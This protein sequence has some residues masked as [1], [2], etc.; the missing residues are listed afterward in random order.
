VDQRVEDG[1]ALRTSPQGKA[2]LELD[3]GGWLL[4][5]QASELTVSASAVTLRAGRVWVDAFGPTGVT[6][7]T[8]HG[9]VV[10]AKAGFEVVVSAADTRVYCGS[11]EVTIKAGA[12]TL[13]IVSGAGGIIAAG[14]I[15]PE[16]K[17]VWTDWTGGLAQAG[18]REAVRTAGLGLL[19][20]RLQSEVGQARS[21]LLVREHKVNARVVGPLAVTTV[22]QHFFNPRSDTVI[23][24]YRVRLPAGAIIRSFAT[25]LAG[26]DLEEAKIAP[27]SRPGGP[28]NPG[29]TVLEWEA[30][31]RYVATL[32]SIARGA[33][34]VVQLEYAEWLPPQGG[35]RRYVYPMGG[36]AAPK[37]GELGIEIDV[38]KAGAKAIKA[39]LDARREGDT[40]VVR[41]SD[42]VPEADLVVEL[43]DAEETPRPALYHARST[44]KDEPAYALLRVVP[45]FPKATPTSTPP[46][47]LVVVA[48]LSAATGEAE[49]AM[50][51][52]TAD[53]L[54]R[55]LTPEDQVGLLVASLDATPLGAGPALGPASPA[56]RDEL[57]AAL[58]KARAGGGTD[59]EAAL[60]AAAQLLPRGE[61]AVVYLGD[62][63]PTLGTLAPGL[64][65]ERLRSRLTPPRIFAVGIGADADLELLTALTEGGGFTLP[66]TDPAAAPRAAL[67][68]AAH[69]AR[70]TLRDVTVEL[71]PDVDRI[72]PAHPITLEAGQTFFAL[73]RLRGTP[74]THA[75]LRGLRDGQPFTT[76]VKLAVAPVEDAGDLQRRWAFGRIQDLLRRG[77]GREAITEI[78]VRYEVVSPFTGLVVGGGSTPFLGQVPDDPAGTYVPEALRG[79][80][81]R[82]GVTLALEPG[83]STSY[84][85]PWSIEELYQQTLA[86]SVGPAVAA[87][88]ERKAASQP[89]LAGS[90]VVTV[91]V[92]PDGAVFK[93]ALL[94]EASTLGDPDIRDDVL[95]LVQAAR[96]PA[97][98]SGER[99][100][101]THTFRFAPVVGYEVPARCQNKDGTRKR[102]PESYQYLDVRRSLWRERLRQSPNPAGAATLW[103]EALVCGEVQLDPD[104]RALLL[105]LLDG[106]GSTRD[107]V[108]LHQ[109]LRHEVPW[110]PAF[111]RREILR[112]LR[113]LDDVTVVRAGLSLDGGVDQAL[114]LRLLAKAKNDAEKVEIV[115]RFHQLAPTSLSLRVMLL[116]LFERT[117]KIADAEELAWGLR[118]DPGVDAGIRQQLAEFFLRRGRMEEARRAFSETVEFA[119]YDPWARRRL[120]HLYLSQAAQAKT[121]SSAKG[122]AW[123]ERLYADAYR[124]FETLAWLV[125]GDPSVLLLMANAAAGMRRIDWALR[126]QERV[127]E[128]AEVGR[129]ENGPAEW[130]R[131][132]TAARLAEL[133]QALAKDAAR[134][135]E[136]KARGR[137]AGLY[138]WARDLSLILTWEH[139]DAQLALR[140]RHPGQ[141]AIVAAPIRGGD[142]AV[143]GVR[144]RLGSLFGPGAAARALRLMKPGEDDKDK[145]KDKDD[146]KR[147]AALKDLENAPLYLEVRVGDLSPDRVTH[148]RGTLLLL[149]KEGAAD[150]KII[151]LPLDLAPDVKALAFLVDATGKITPTKVFEPP[152]PKE[153]PE[154]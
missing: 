12:E 14:K 68:I 107:R 1:A 90:V 154:D 110:V 100:T 69:A 105:V 55:Q 60:L 122:P 66:V 62:G 51:R 39:G 134:L 50:I 34:V 145:K 93:A 84:V 11:A 20:G 125:P 152:K 9:S 98:P 104:A 45:D 47:K 146:A 128:S 135:A 136:V 144:F 147:S 91:E 25:G 76:K 106:L 18:P 56:R 149:W 35:R 143:E 87:A 117:G 54:F 82:H 116:R 81:P 99:L 119:P 70:P 103:R 133:R 115:R 59:L 42:Y 43:L 23:G 46:L 80:P 10:G 108:T 118:S 97:P 123:V 85:R 151:S 131:L 48:D 15:T 127:S 101:F 141:E 67:A 140:L 77:A 40:L 19:E 21:P 137:R 6:V 72:Y 37:L 30:P 4:V 22:Q 148:Y 92:N 53:A 58:G 94:A 129:A 33:T 89:D 95:R 7:T 5:D 78:G 88:Y 153:R 139:P 24:T 113:T 3:A 49:V 31:D 96:L 32:A 16:L 132:L 71:G 65:R 13:R 109:L 102:S 26:A 27:R 142:V 61:G 36:G 74:P 130:G 57:L 64:L 79:G 29:Q 112:R 75:T 17:I 86:R 41:R 111:L 63:R 2:G 73:G 114:L 52:A 138:T 120:G 8:A 83:W 121:L 38:S 124:E 126:L 28:G 150:E 44:V